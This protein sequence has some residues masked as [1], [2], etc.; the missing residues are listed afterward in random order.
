VDRVLA[1]GARTSDLASDPTK[2][3]GCRA[4][5]DRLLEAL[6]ANKT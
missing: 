3:L 6:A 5:G 2:A 1:D 4:M